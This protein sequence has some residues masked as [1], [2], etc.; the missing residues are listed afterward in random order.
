M[1][2]LKGYWICPNGNERQAELF[3]AANLDEAFSLARIFWKGA[4][5]WNWIKGPC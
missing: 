5:F 4:R 3:W 2:P 1:T